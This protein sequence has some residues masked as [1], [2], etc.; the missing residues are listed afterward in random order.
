[1]FDRSQGHVASVMSSQQFSVENTLSDARRHS[2]GPQMIVQPN[3]RT[4]VASTDTNDDDVYKNQV[5]SVQETCE[6]VHVSTRG[7]RKVERDIAKC[8]NIEKLM[9]K[10]IED[11]FKGFEELI[12][13]CRQ[14]NM[15]ESDQEDKFSFKP[16]RK[17]LMNLDNIGISELYK[18]HLK[19]EF[20]SN[21]LHKLLGESIESSRPD[22]RYFLKFSGLQVVNVDC[23][24]GIVSDTQPISLPMSKMINLFFLSCDQ[25]QQVIS[26]SL[27]LNRVENQLK[28]HL[29]QDLLR[30]KMYRVVPRVIRGDYF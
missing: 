28:L 16:K 12:G 29:D 6:N 21:E 15:V 23:Q 30:S 11:A 19:Y 25:L 9:Q 4:A 8:I 10:P 27:R 3:Q 13:S 22:R 5:D 26:E 24:S 7:I 17:G 14:E 18:D 1:M 20:K 2:V